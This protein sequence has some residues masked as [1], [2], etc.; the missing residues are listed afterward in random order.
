MSLYNSFIRSSWFRS[1]VFWIGNVRKLSS[2]PWVTW[3]SHEPKISHEEIDQILSLVRPG[4]VGVH[5]DRGFLS[6]CFIPGIFKH[7]WIHADDGQVIEAI[8]A[9]VVCRSARYTLR[10]D[11]LVILRP[12][13]SAVVRKSAVKNAMKIVGFKYDTAYDFDI[14]EE[15]QHL[16]KHDQAFSCIETV[17]YAYYPYFNELNFKWE[18]YLGKKVLYPGVVVNPAFDV[19]YSNVKGIEVTL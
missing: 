8:K 13:L 19:V 11:D 16:N 9:G 17:A 14:D 15:L 6:N 7:A 1:F 10:T 2:F 3:D 18:Q 12:K 5:R 4:D